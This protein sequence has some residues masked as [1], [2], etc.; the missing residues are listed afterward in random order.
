MAVH[1]AGRFTHLTP[2]GLKQTSEESF[3]ENLGAKHSG[4]ARLDAFS[5]SIIDRLNNE[6]ST[7][8]TWILKGGSLNE[9][10]RHR[11]LACLIGGRCGRIFS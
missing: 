6:S 7:K 9:L 1:L 11:L 2:L 4:L 10:S 3:D 8:L 5:T